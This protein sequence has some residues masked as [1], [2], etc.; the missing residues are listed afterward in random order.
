MSGLIPILLI[1]VLLQPASSEML[2]LIQ[3]KVV[4]QS[5]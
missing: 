4:M 1:L 5:E 3:L 2:H